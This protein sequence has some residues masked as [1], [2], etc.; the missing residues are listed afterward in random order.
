MGW[1][2]PYLFVF[3]VMMNVLFLGAQVY[4][5]SHKPTASIHAQKILDEESDRDAELSE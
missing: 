5:Q 2:V 3:L 1:L 4:K